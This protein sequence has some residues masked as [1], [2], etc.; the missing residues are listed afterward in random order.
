MTIE[1]RNYGK[2]H[3]YKIDG[4]K[5]PGVTTILGATVPKPA[6]INWAADTTAAFAVDYW[7]ALGE[8][9]P[10]KRLDRLKKARYEDRDT[11][12]NRGTQV[13]AIAEQYVAGVEV[14]IPDELDGHVRS[15][16]RFIEEWNV[17]EVHTEV[18]VANRATWYCGTVDLIADL[19]DGHRW[20]LDLKT[21]RSGIFPETALQLTAYE[22]AEVYATA[23]KGA[24]EEHPMAELGITHV[25]AVHVTADGYELIPIVQR[26]DVWAYFRH[27]AWLYRLEDDKSTW[28]GNPL[29]ARRRKV[30]S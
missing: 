30:A 17:E 28:F 18:V 16:Q 23:E 10:S 20:L 9:T 15:Y 12:A 5:V 25:G 1:R 8:L 24:L 22:H 13:H 11:A 21:S 6:L 26:D 4:K 14:E 2:G 29:P 7:E 19:V 3:S 27:L